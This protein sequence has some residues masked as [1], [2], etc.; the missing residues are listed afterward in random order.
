MQCI[1]ERAVTNKRADARSYHHPTPP[2]RAGMAT[3]VLGVWRAAKRPGERET[4]LARAL[5]IDGD[6]EVAP[7]RRRTQACRRIELE[8]VGVGTDGEAATTATVLATAECGMVFDGGGERQLHRRTRALAGAWDADIEAWRKA[9]GERPR[10]TTR[11]MQVRLAWRT[12]DD[13]ALVPAD[14]VEG[15]VR[16]FEGEARHRLHLAGDPDPDGGAPLQLP[17]VLRVVCVT[18]GPRVFAVAPGDGGALRCT[19]PGW[20]GDLAVSYY[21]YL[22]PPPPPPAIPV[23]K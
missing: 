23:H 5:A 7:I 13:V 10:D 6:G 22:P 4:F 16:A 17:T 21:L 19:A 20:R 2:S 8:W 18:P 3:T 15:L 1:S 11:H 12:D 9:R 14:F